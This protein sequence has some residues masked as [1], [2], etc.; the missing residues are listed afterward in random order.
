MIRRLGRLIGLV[1][2][3]LVA[4]FVAPVAR[5][6]N[7]DTVVRGIVSVLFLTLLA[8]GMTQLL[9]MHADLAGRVDGLVV[10][11]V[12]IVVFFAF[13]FYVL[14]LHHPGQVTGLVTRVDALYFAMSTMSTIGYGDIHAQ[15][16]VARM[17]VIVQIIFDL[18]FVA[19]AAS[20][21]TARLRMVAE[22]RAERAKEL[23]VTEPAPR[24]RVLRRR[25]SPRAEP[26]ARDRTP[27]GGGPHR[28]AP[29]AEAGAPS[30]TAPRP[31]HSSK[32]AR[33]VRGAASPRV[34]D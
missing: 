4:Y 22:Q 2:L 5:D 13:G 33:S 34:V 1:T 14:E 25:S 19:A 32:P 3:I 7:P 17:L 15:G 24:R 30:L 23:G 8:V 21:L 10:G 6:I 16:Q 29:P 18:V 11:I 27:D 12:V 9:R 26:E 31:S 28:V 20:L